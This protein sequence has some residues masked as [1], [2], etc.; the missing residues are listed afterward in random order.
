MAMMGVPIAL[1]LGVP[2]GTFLGNIVGWYYIFGFMAILNLISVIWIIIKVPDYQGQSHKSMVS[3][4]SIF[5]TSGVCHIL[6][7]I[8]TWILSH[9]IIYTY[10][11]PFVASLG[12][13][14]HIDLALFIFGISAIVGIW[15][16]GLFIDRWLRLLI[17]VSIFI[18]LLHS[19]LF[20]ISINNLISIYVCTAIWGLTFG[21]FFYAIKYSTC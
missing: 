5:K 1:A 15:I 9:N 13:V 21:G 16:V 3:V 10:I 12:M 4:L 18:F 20:G 17:L 19:I 11:N 14:N 6:F 2:V 8:M 7:V